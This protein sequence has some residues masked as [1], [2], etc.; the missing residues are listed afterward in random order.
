MLQISV[1]ALKSHPS[2]FK[3]KRQDMINCEPK[4][5][6]S[7]SSG[8]NLPTERAPL[9]KYK[10]ATTYIGLVAF[11]QQRIKSDLKEFLN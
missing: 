6:G 8:L 10:F 2:I 4:R 5:K 9:G 11:Q 7:T 1:L 3:S